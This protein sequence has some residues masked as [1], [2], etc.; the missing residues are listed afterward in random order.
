ME[1]VDYI[2]VGQGIAGSSLAFRMLDAGLAVRIFDPRPADASSRVAAGIVNPVTGRKLVKSWMIDELLVEV[3]ALY[4]GFEAL[5]G[6]QFLYPMPIYKALQ[7]AGE[8]NDWLA[9]RMEAGR[10]EYMADIRFPDWE[11]V[12]ADAGVGT[13]LN[14]FWLDIEGLLSGYG[15]EL[16]SKGMLIPSVFETSDLELFPGGGVGYRDLRARAVIFCE[17][18]TGRDNPYFRGLPLSYAKGEIMTIRCE[19]LSW[20]DGILN[21]NGFIIPLGDQLFRVGATFQWNDL[22]S[23]PTDQGR[24]DLRSRLERLVSCNYEIVDIRAGFRPTTKDRRPMLGRSPVHP[25]VHIFN[26]LGTKGVS[27][28]AWF[29]LHLFRHL[30][31]GETLLPEVDIRRFPEIFAEK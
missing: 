31:L 18:Y 19:D 8:Q 20:L 1:Q 11:M 15:Q 23:K 27:L 12:N 10:E 6:R 16:L 17:G 29:S 30:E 4:A 2:I 5:L 25:D 21:R 28:A 26:G 14:G 13:I 3:R 24:A 9:R 7:T 22:S